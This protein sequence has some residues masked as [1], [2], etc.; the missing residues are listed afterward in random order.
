MRTLFITTTEA[1][2]Y[3]TARAELAL[4]QYAWNT[5]RGCWS[6]HGH[7]KVVLVNL[8]PWGDGRWVSRIV[9][10]LAPRPRRGNVPGSRFKGG[11]H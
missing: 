4:H 3:Q 5:G 2:A 1:E 11:S 7:H 8:G 10:Q 6:S 9:R